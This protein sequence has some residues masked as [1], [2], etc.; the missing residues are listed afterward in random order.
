MDDK[1][2]ATVE[3]AQAAPHPEDPR[4]P[5]WPLQLGRGSW[6]YALRRAW[7]KFLVDLDMDG[8]AAL[9]YYAIMS[10]FPALLAMVTLLSVVGQG[11]ATTAWILEVLSSYAPPDV[12]DFLAGP[13]NHLTTQSNA[14]WLLVVSTL[15]AVW[16]AGG[17]VGAFGRVMN[18][19]YG[20]AE[21]RPIWKIIPY[22]VLLTVLTLLF[23]VATMLTVLLSGT[24]AKFVGDLFGV[25]NAAVEIWNN[26]KWPVLAVAA[27][28]Y[29]SC[30]YYATPNVKQ[31]RFRWITIG[32]VI[33]LVVMAIAVGAFTFYVSNFGNFNATYGAIGSVIV[34][35]LG[36]WIINL[37][38]L[39]GGEMDAEIERVRQLQ[40]GIEAESLIQ[41]PPRDDR[42]IKVLARDEERFIEQGAEIRTRYSHVDYDREDGDEAAGAGGEP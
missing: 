5:R 26:V 11:E 6:L 23:G 8:A 27:I 40:G 34:L 15:I 21:G 39:F 33:A 32:S 3:N 17:Y 2:E 22:N 31:T 37:A 7:W 20:V 41:L 29:M 16:S 13:I 35:L 25:G 28:F 14:G 38:L 42:M 30:L 4:K 9:T 36:I 24:V 10:L 12:V 18:R 19:I 1:D